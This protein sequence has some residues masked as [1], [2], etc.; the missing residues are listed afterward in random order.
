MN[1]GNRKVGTEV[2]LMVL[3]QSTNRSQKTERHGFY[4][5]FRR[6]SSLEQQSE[7]GIVNTMSHSRI[8]RTFLIVTESNEERQFFYLDNWYQRQS[9]HAFNDVVYVAEQ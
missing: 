1:L 9:L 6:S 2:E 7:K 5:K 8:D 3:A 4:E